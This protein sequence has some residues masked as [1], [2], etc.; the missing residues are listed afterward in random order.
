M[1]YVQ[2]Y[3]EMAASKVAVFWKIKTTLSSEVWTRHVSNL[4]QICSSPNISKLNALV[5]LCFL[6]FK[7]IL[8]ID[9]D[10][11]C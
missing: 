10:S 6:S 2:V 11:V 7:L 4:N 8:F 9:L 5:L 3:F 1:F